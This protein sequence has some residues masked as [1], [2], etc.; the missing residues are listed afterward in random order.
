MSFPARNS[1]SFFAGSAS[2]VRAD[3]SI[4]IFSVMISLRSAGTCLPA[5]RRT[6]SPI[7][8]SAASTVCS[9]PSRLTTAFSRVIFSKAS[10]AFF[11]FPSCII[12][13]AVLRITTAAII[14][15]SASSPKRTEI[16]P[17]AARTYRNGSASWEKS[18][19]KKDGPAHFS[20]SFG[21][22]LFRRLFTAS[23]ESPP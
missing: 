9:I 3:S 11:A 19:D 8:S 12:P 10:S 7:T 20:T 15:A 6:R 4:C 23:R 5:S 13:T 2:P 14:Q 1:A 21:P 18:R 22:K 17:A 16:P